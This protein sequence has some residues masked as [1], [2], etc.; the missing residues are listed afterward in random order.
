MNRNLLFYIFETFRPLFSEE[1]V[2]STSLSSAGKNDVKYL[3]TLNMP[4]L[5]DI[6][7]VKFH[8]EDIFC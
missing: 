8:Y 2:Y 1:I 3:L 7:I 5:L 4:L 6:F